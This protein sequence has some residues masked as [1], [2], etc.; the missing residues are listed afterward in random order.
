MKLN[1]C[2]IFGHVWIPVYIKGEIGGK[3]VRFIGAECK[4]CLKGHED[5]R[6]F[7]NE[8]DSCEYNTYNEKYYDK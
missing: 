4:K 7:I 2:K 1:F 8:L 3:P 5:L 6:D